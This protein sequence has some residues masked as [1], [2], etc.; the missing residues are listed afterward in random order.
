MQAS[1]CSAADSSD[2]HSLKRVELQEK[3]RMHVWWVVAFSMSK[4]S[5][6]DLVSDGKRYL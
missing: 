4:N 3:K 6:T 1:L 5:R 2:G